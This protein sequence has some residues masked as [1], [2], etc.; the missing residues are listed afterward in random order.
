MFW[1]TA[2]VS[3]EKPLLRSPQE[4]KKMLADSGIRPGTKIVSYCEVGWQATYTYFIAKYLGY[5]AAMYDGSYVEWNAAKQPV[6]RGAN[7]R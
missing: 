3:Q 1:E 6:V 5:D 7:P 2:L 4:L